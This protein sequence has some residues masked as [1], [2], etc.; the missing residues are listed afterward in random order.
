[1]AKTNED[2]GLGGPHELVLSRLLHV[3]RELAFRVWTS[4]QHLAN[5]WGPR[6]DAGR[7]FST[8][9]IEVDF[10]VGGHYRICIRSPQGEDYWQRGTYREIDAP[11]RIVFSFAWEEPEGSSP[12]TFVT[13]TFEE[14][15]PEQT[16]LTFRQT[17]FPTLEARD[18]HQGGWGEVL[19][20][21]ELQLGRQH[22]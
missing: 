18:S 1:M 6:D 19:D 14:K 22:A 12:L 2:A 15:G 16:L 10:R 4:P 8:P 11:E 20:R 17:G 9:S 21:F 13:V 7:D 5:W 3:P